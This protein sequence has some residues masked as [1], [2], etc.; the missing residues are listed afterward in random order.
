MYTDILDA[1]NA[2][3][4]MNFEDASIILENCINTDISFTEILRQV[5][6]IPEFLEHDSTEEKL[7]F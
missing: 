4:D 3:V 2:A 5:G 7:F 1:I 6:T